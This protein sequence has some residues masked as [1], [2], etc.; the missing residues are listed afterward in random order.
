MNKLSTCSCA[1]RGET[2]EINNQQAHTHRTK[3]DP[4]N[5]PQGINKQTKR[6]KVKYRFRPEQI[7]RVGWVDDDIVWIARIVDIEVAYFRS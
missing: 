7:V 6:R 3:S 2:N 1:K 4:V 5:M